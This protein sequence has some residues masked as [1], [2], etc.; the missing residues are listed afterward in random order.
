MYCFA[1]RLATQ[2]ELIVAGG[3]IQHGQR[4]MEWSYHGTSLVQKRLMR[5]GRM[6][7]G[8]PGPAGPEDL[9]C[10]IRVGVWGLYGLGFRV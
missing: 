5:H 10:G 1:R 6:Y 3:T 7:P 2:S 4:K 9:D 8:A